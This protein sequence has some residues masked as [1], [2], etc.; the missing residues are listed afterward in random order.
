MRSLFD[1]YGTRIKRYYAFDPV[2]H[3]FPKLQETARSFAGLAHVECSNIAFDRENASKA[4]Q[5]GVPRSSHISSKGDIMVDCRRLDD[6]SLEITGKA[7]LKMD[8]EGMEMAALMGAAGFI[9]THKPH[10][11]LCLYHKTNDIYK[12]PQYIKSLAPEYEFTLAGG[13][14][15][16]CYGSVK[17]S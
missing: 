16:L 11:A 8:I 6:L 5:T 4:F 7:C 3:I 15:T 14:H 12:I 10:L 2:P 1:A 13:V 9:K 17:T